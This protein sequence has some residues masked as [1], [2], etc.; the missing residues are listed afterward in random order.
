MKSSL[1]SN[2]KTL[3]SRLK[4]TYIISKTNCEVVPFKGIYITG[5]RKIKDY[6][7]EKI[8]LECCDCTAIL[9]GHELTVENLLNGQMSVVGKIESLEFAK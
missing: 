7:K 3:L 5:C 2:K 1:N 8:V 4:Q 6:S 9:S